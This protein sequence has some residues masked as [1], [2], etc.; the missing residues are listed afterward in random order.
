MRRQPVVM[1]SSPPEHAD[2]YHSR[3]RQDSCCGRDK[4]N[5]SSVAETLPEVWGFL[6]KLNAG[7]NAGTIKSTDELIKRCRAFYTAE[8]MAKIEAVV[9]G[10]K[11]M[12]SFDDGKTL[13]HIN[14][15]MLALLQLDEYRSMSP[16]R[17]AVEQ[18]IVFLHDIAK[19]P[20]AGRDHRHSFRSAAL[21]G[22]ILPKLG[23]PVTAAYSSEFQD[24][25]NLTDTAT[26]LDEAKVPIQDNSKLPKILSGARRIFAEPTRTAVSAIALHQSITSLAAWPVKAPL[27]DDQVMAYV[28]KEIVPALLV[29]TL[30]D[31]GGWNLF[32]PP[33]LDS[34]YKETRAVFR[35]LP[36]SPSSRQSRSQQVTI[37]Q[38]SGPSVRQPRD[39]SAIGVKVI[40]W[41][42]RDA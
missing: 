39:R 4:A 31:S 20:E 11:H 18:W 23:F 16:G 21:A 24:W 38:G 3:R 32:D 40:R 2:S 10:W 19:E 42:R 1:R 29:L 7:V 17:Q 5:I 36:R 12:A 37:L 33:T 22:R 8:R 9:P 28:G 25:F 30:A 35:D 27:T 41:A 26:R 13:W 6:Q 15:A 14:V 34:M